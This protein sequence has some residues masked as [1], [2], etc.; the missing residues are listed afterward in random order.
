M[1]KRAV[2]RPDDAAS[3]MGGMRGGLEALLIPRTETPPPGST[4]APD[5]EEISERE[6]R[7]ALAAAG[8]AVGL[9]DREGRIRDPN[10][11]L[12]ALA[13]DLEPLAHDESGPCAGYQE[14]LRGERARLRYTRRFKHRDGHTGWAR[15]TL[16]PLGEPSEPVRWMLL[17][18]EDIT[19]HRELQHRIRHLRM[20]DPLTRLPNRE[21][22]LERLSGALG[23]GAT[24]TRVGLCHLDLDGLRAVNDTLGHRVG[25]LLLA[26]AAERLAMCVSPLGHLVARLGGDEFAVLIDGSRGTAEATGVAEALLEA[27]AAPFEIEGQRLALT[28][29]IGVVE[30]PVRATTPSSLLQAAHAALYW[31]R[32]EGRGRWALFDP[33]RNAR[34]VTRQ[35]LCRTLPSAVEREEFTVEYQPLVD[36][37]D[38][39]LRGVEALA[40]WHH[41]ELG[42]LPPN[43]FIGLAEES[44]AIVQLGRWVLTAACRQARRWQL[45]HPAAA[46]PFVSVNVAV[47]QIWDSDLVADVA[48]ALDQTGLPPHLLQLELTESAE[49]GPGGPPLR[50]LH[51]LAEMG[52]GITLDDFGTG[53]S[54]LAYLSRLPVRGLKLDGTFMRGFGSGRHPNPADRAVVTALVRLAHELGLTVT[55]ECVEN[56]EQAGQL[57]SIGCDLAQGWFYAR[58][59]P[60]ERID[61]MLRTAACG[62]GSRLPAQTMP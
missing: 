51:K 30:R 17:T 11:A 39:A 15:V 49:V 54:N 57:R 42:T 24:A 41:P 59:G 45:A 47:R 52:V 55:A 58:S 29:S 16:T 62:A 10:R 9:V 13:E 8:I 2:D 43:R 44:G 38:G 23:D 36:L 21:L 40:R 14:L 5:A 1:R 19:G 33:E 37:E 61:A 50:A 31:A 28:A 25:D 46:S 18:A 35:T 6:V 27:L 7:D 56:A 32:A 20:H 60:P 53:Y 48:A 3:A 22:F 4:P 26:A 12:R 34:R